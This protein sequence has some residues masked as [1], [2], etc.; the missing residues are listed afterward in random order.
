[1]LNLIYIKLNFKVELLFF[2]RLGHPIFFPSVAVTNDCSVNYPSLLLD[3][4][5]QTKRCY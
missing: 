3:N 5:E 4:A 2:R 1:M